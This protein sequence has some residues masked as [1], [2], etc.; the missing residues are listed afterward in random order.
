M[1]GGFLPWLRAMDMQVMGACRT[2]ERLKPLLKL[3]VSAGVAEGWSAS[4]SQSDLRISFNGDDG[5]VERLITLS[6]DMQCTNAEIVEIPADISGSMKDLLRRKPLLAELTGIS[7]SR[8][9]YF[10]S[11]LRSHLQAYLTDTVLSNAQAA[12]IL[13]SNPTYGSAYSS[14]PR[15]SQSSFNFPKSSRSKT[16]LI[17]LGSLSPRPS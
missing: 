10:A 2:D 4:S 7:N 11:H 3:N 17:Y 13:S 14:V 15:S 12:G 5:S 1:D 8:L 9:N 6:T 16:T